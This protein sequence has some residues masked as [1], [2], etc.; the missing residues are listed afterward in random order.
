MCPPDVVK[1]E[2]AGVGCCS[3]VGSEGQLVIQYHTQVSCSPSR[4]HHRVL[5]DNGEVMDG[6]FLPWKEEQLGLVKTEL[7]LVC[8]HPLGDISQT[9][10]DLCCHLGFRLGKRQ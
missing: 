4:G 9:R 6:R 8:R 2:S 5:D 7:Q 3:N 1:D 10:R